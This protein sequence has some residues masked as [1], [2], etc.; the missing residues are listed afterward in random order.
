M[1]QEDEDEDD[2]GQRITREDQDMRGTTEE[3]DPEM[4]T[5]LSKGRLGRGKRQRRERSAFTDPSCLSTFVPN[6]RV[7]AFKFPSQ[8]STQAKEGFAFCL[9]TGETLVIHG[10][11]SIT[12]L[13]GSLSVLGSVLSTSPSSAIPRKSFKLFAPSSHPLPPLEA[14]QLPLGEPTTSLSLPDGTVVD[15]SSFSAVVLVEDYASGIEGVEKVLRAGSLGGGN[16]MWPFTSALPRESVSFWRGTTWSL[17]TELTPSLTVLRMPGSWSSTLADIAP[18]TMRSQLP[19]NGNIDSGDENEDEKHQEKSGDS[20]R[21]VF[22]VEGPRH[23]GKS[24]LV[25]QVMNRLLSRYDRVAYLDA[26]LG[27]PEF[28]PSGFVSLNVVS[29]PILGPP[30][31]HPSIPAASH[32]LG[33]TS[34]ASDPTTYLSSISA[35]LATYHLEVEFPPIDEPVHRSHRRGATH[36]TSL[37][38]IADRV[39]LLINTQG[40]VKGLGADLLLQIKEEARPTHLLSFYSPDEDGEGALPPPPQGVTQYRLEPAPSSPLDAKWSAADLR[41]L[42]FVGYFHSSFADGPRPSSELSQIVSSWNFA[43]PLVST[44]PLRTSWDDRTAIRQVHIINGEVD[45]EQ[46][47]HALNGS[48]VALVRSRGDDEPERCLNLSSFPYEPYAPPPNPSSSRSLGLALIRAIDPSSHS[49][50]LLTPVPPTVLDEEPVSL[51]MGSI[52]I[53][54][55]LTFDFKANDFDREKGLCGVEWKDV[56]YIAAGGEGGTGRRKVRRNLMRRSQA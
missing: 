12:P 31:T 27:Q 25:R 24:T 56:P 38:K 55:C 43:L 6:L 19:S 7:N 44:P 36:S 35:L 13:F 51:V 22:L 54:M 45:K 49:L 15:V 33:N 2:E 18:S 53:P 16:G 50:L 42:A 34:P 5:T 41:T 39:P 11:A 37:S 10:T 47:L 4:P 46:T 9:R 23:V 32:F 40:W 28:T 26:D 20:D 48:V 29:E 52:E 21:K 8:E 1:P 14:L 3:E 17:I 30:F